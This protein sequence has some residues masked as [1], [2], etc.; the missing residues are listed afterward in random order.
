MLTFC[1]WFL[2]PGIH[3]ALQIRFQGCDP[4]SADDDKD[5]FIKSVANPESF[6]PASYD[7][8]DD[9]V[10]FNNSYGSGDFG[11]FGYCTWIFK[12]KGDTF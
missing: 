1:V 5:T 9:Y 7:A 12:N 8:E 11:P 10:S 6:S 2:V 4:L 3:R